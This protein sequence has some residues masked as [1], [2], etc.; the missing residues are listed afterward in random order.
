[1]IQITLSSNSECITMRVSGHAGAGKTGK[2]TICASASILAYTVAQALKFMHFKGA[3]IK[4]PHIK[5]KEGS[6]VIT[7]FPKA[8]AY[9]EAFHTFFVAQVGFS[10]LQHNYPDFVSLDITQFGKA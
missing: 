5:L 1:M 6:T 8:E 3:L 7:A 2:D 10:L 4:R 9:E